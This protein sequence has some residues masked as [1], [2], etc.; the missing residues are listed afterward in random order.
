MARGPSDLVG[1]SRELARLEELAAASLVTLC[2][3][4]GVGKTRLAREHAEAARR[5]G[6]VVAWAD[7]ASSR[8]RREV[9]TSIAAALG[10]AIVG[11]DD[12]DVDALGRAT[13]ARR[14]LLVADNLE[15]IDG[16][17]RAAVIRLA[18]ATSEGACVLVTSRELLGAQH[19]IEIAVAPLDDDDGVALFEALTGGAGDATTHAIVRRLDALPLAIELAAARV[20]LLG[21]PELLARLD[22]KLDELGTA[23]ADR[24]ARHA[25]LRATIVWSWELL[26]DSERDAL[27]GCAT[28]EAPFDAA[29]AG[30]VIGGT[31]AEALDRLERLGSHALVHASTDPQGRVTFRLLESVRDF[32]REASEA[33]DARAAETAGRRRA[34]HAAAIV[35]RAE[36]LA[37]AA[38]C[39]RDTLAELAALRADLGAA[40]RGGGPTGAR[41]TL[42]LAALVGIS[43]PASEAVSSS[44]AALAALASQDDLLAVRLLVA[45]GA[46]LRALG[47]LLDARDVLEH[48]VTGANA[49]VRERDAELAGAEAGRVL[50]SVLRS[51]GHVEEALVHLERALATYRAIGDRA[52]EGICLGE[53]GAVHQS[54]GRFAL[55]RRCHAEAIAI[56]VAMGSRHAEGIERSYLA[57]ATHRAG[58]PAAS[59][60]LHEAALA[61]HREAGHRRLEGAELL[62]LGF[63][64]SEL[65]AIPNARE[66][67]VAARRVLATAGAPELLASA[68][69]FSAR[70]EVDAGNGSAALPLLA[71][72]SRATPANWPRLVATRHLVEGHLAM[73]T[74]APARAKESYEAALA[75]SRDLEVGFEALTPAYL[76]LAAARAGSPVNEALLDEA[77][78]RAQA[79]ENSHLRVAFEVLAACATGDAAVEIPAAAT[80][81]SSEVSRAMTFAAAQ[82]ALSIEDEGRCVMLP[83]GRAID[84]S[85]RKNV[86]RVLLAL[87]RARRDSPGAPVL[88]AILLEAGWPGER[89][90]AEAATKRLH[91]AIWTLRNVGLEA[92]L[93][94]E[95]E[96]Y[97]LDPRTDL[98]L[99]AC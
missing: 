82:R 42:A 49:L 86:R 39:G 79:L 50:G 91:T 71:E 59:L 87:A 98:R 97:L 20:P 54:E 8:T 75:T 23:R 32:A 63:V 88:P 28:F 46:G 22:R 2:G 61:I 34:R 40:A 90:R 15:Q 52:R 25:T 41:A 83:G 45:K 58:D 78:A 65:G 37:E 47:R 81:A 29:L 36:P 30:A 19:E 84:L 89:M 44:E 10:V 55:A 76:A 12:A 3:P 94:T 18:P 38:G 77:R 51:L 4:G 67:F 72:A 66:A 6:R 9:V 96:G 93:L 26:D 69:V 73:A 99:D 31:E 85:R 17:A 14:A 70:L 74:G 5:R 13:A 24:L 27:M 16:E 57:V 60:A 11:T 56:H 35:D 68:L 21:T 48:A 53:I 33:P 43:G 1:R 64:H 95:G 92:L 80:M 7:L 62:H